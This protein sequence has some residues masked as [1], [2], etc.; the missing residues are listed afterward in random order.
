ML[1]WVLRSR[2]GMPWTMARNA[3]TRNGRLT[4]PAGWFRFSD[5]MVRIFDR[6]DVLLKKVAAL[7][8]IG[9]REYSPNVIEWDEADVRA[10]NSQLAYLAGEAKY[11]LSEIHHG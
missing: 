6:I 2:F 3:D 8:S 10:H 11:L 1:T 5:A 7:E 4:S 9:P